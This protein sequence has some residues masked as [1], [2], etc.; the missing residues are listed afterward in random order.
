VAERPKLF[1]IDAEMQRWCA[2]LEQELLAWPEV[3]AKPM[4]GMIGFYCGKNIFATIPRTKAAESPR[5]ILIKLPAVKH[6]RLKS[7]S[8]PDSAWAA[9]ELES[10]NDIPEALRWLEQAYQRNSDRSLRE[11]E[12][13]GSYDG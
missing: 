10:L 9:F 4:F 1:A 11:M 5:S 13:P 3:S 7:A 6:R 8:G 2:L 12:T